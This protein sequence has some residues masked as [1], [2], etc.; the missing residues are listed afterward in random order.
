MFCSYPSS[1][2]LFAY[3]KEKFQNLENTFVAQQNP[4]FK[5]IIFIMDFK[6]IWNLKL[7][8]DVFDL[9]GVAFSL[10]QRTTE[11]LLKQ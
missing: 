4:A 8:Y 5:I 9:S 2:L 10:K 11:E 6:T 1:T 7:S 3:L